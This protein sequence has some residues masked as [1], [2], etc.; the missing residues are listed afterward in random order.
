MERSAAIIELGGWLKTPPGQ[1]LL[2]WE[3]ERIDTAVSD[4]F[5][6]HALQMG[7]PALDGLR[8][9]RMPHRWLASESL[10]VPEP[11]PI[12]PPRDSEISTQPLSVP[13]ALHCAPEALPFASN[14]IDLI[15]MPHALEMSADPH[16]ALAEATRV[17]VP[18]GRLVIVGFNPMSLWALRQRL[19]R[20]GHSLRMGDEELFL[21]SAGEFIG[22]WRLRD[23]LRLLSYDI[24]VGKFGCYRPPWNSQRWL[25]RYG[26]MERVGERWWPVLG[27]VYFLVAV[28]RVRGMHLV[29][30]VRKE[31]VKAS[32]AP[33]VVPTH[34]RP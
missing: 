20:T 13:V 12:A 22:Y 26:W 17:L 24:E 14:S 31:R 34:R 8:A 33:A 19:G 10:F 1:V 7:L 2:A 3:Q 23:W 18:E 6:Y 21:P 25:D 30:K 28:R 4:I 9:N 29:G 32:S 15:V 5:G 11:Q 27:A 16:A